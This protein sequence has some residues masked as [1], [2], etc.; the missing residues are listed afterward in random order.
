MEFH[1]KRLGFFRGRKS[2]EAGENPQ[3]KNKN[4]Q[5]TKPM[6]D[7]EPRTQTQD[8]LVRSDQHPAVNTPSIISS[9]DNFPGRLLPI[10]AYTGRLHPKGVPFSGFRYIKGQGLHKLRYVQ[11]VGKSVI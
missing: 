8:T 6:N 4:K 5:Q 9:K 7:T 11:R 2:R 1:N 10:M 3:R